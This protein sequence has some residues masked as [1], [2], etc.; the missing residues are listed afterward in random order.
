MKKVENLSENQKVLCEIP[1]KEIVEHLIQQEYVLS[2]EN[3]GI[4][5]LTLPNPEIKSEK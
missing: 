2:F 5:Y 1:I 3:D 4:L